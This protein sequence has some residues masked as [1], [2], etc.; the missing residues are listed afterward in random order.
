MIQ[1]SKICLW[2]KPELALLFS[3]NKTAHSWFSCEHV[4][5]C[6][7][8]LFLL[9][10]SH[11]LCHVMVVQKCLYPAGGKCSF[12]FFTENLGCQS[13]FPLQKTQPGGSVCEMQR[14]WRLWK[15]SVDVSCAGTTHRGNSSVGLH[16]ETRAHLRK[17]PERERQTGAD[18]NLVTSLTLSHVP[19]SP[20]PHL[21]SSQLWV[22]DFQR[23][24]LSVCF[25]FSFLFSRYLLSFILWLLLPTSFIPSSPCLAPLPPSH[26]LS[27]LIANTFIPL[28]LPAH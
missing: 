23:C 4:L 7:L 9:V 12:H 18:W 19:P 8:S 5:V 28:R 14:L 24:S 16:R 13:A 27:P 2:L 21:S 22:C 26:S 17:R 15:L 3:V 1:Y 10:L 6:S 11:L 20:L 25:G